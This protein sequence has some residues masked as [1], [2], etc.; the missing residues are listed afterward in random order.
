MRRLC[1]RFAAIGICSILAGC[2]A[3][4]ESLLE[5]GRDAMLVVSELPSVDSTL[6]NKG[7]AS[8]QTFVDR[9]P[10]DS[11]ADSALFMM[12]S[13]QDII[14]QPRK[15]A[16]N[17]LALLRQYPESRYRPNSLILAGHIYERIHDFRRA[18]ACY[19]TLMR[20]FPKNEFVRG[21]SAQWLLD[22]MNAPPED[23]PVPFAADSLAP[24]T[25]AT[26]AQPP[27]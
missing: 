10:A 14:G 26:A 19:E 9:Y 3:S 6:I 7:I 17:F 2:S 1:A 24:A 27:S 11:R 13:L 23:W 5:D 16:E 4:P 22:N 12:A 21:G 15:A 25:S 8:L 18:R 20:D